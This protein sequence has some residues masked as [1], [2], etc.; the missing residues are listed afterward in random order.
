MAASKYNIKHRLKQYTN[1][2]MYNWI[3]FLKKK[4]F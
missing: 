4:K 2:E 1:Q 3:R